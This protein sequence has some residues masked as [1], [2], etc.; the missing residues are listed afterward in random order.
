MLVH[1][2]KMAGENG[3]G[4]PC[5]GTG[6]RTRAAALSAAVRHKV[7][8]LLLQVDACWECEWW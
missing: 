8:E 5:G 2:N 6:P 3:G 4:W 1:E 7:P